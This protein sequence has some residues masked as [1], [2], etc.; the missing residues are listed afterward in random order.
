MIIKKDQKNKGFTLIELMVSVTIFS[1]ALVLAMGAVLTIIDLNRKI[2][3]MSSVTNNVNFAMESLVRIIKSSEFIYDSTASDE[4]PI[5]ET[6]TQVRLE[7]IDTYEIF[8]E[9]PGKIRKDVYYRHNCTDG[10]LERALASSGGSPSNWNRITS[11]DDLNIRRIEFNVN[12]SNTQQKIELLMD[13]LATVAS[14][15]SE[16]II[17]TTATRRQY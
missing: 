7:Y 1:I 8:P 12:N 15:T 2:Q 5:G 13:G 6:K 9:I 10:T 16:F 4:C 14:E 3:A 11:N 17:Q